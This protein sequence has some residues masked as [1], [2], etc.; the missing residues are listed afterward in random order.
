MTAGAVATWVGE[1]KPARVSA[2]AF[3]LGAVDP[4][5]VVTILVVSRELA[6]FGPAAA[7]TAMRDDLVAALAKTIDDELLDETRAPVAGANPG[8]ILNGVAPIAPSGV[9]AAAAAKDA[10]K[11]VAAFVTANPDTTRARILLPP[12][13]AV[14]IKSARPL[15]PLTLTGGSYLGVP[16]IVSG[17][18]GNRIVVVDGGQLLVADDGAEIDASGQATVQMDSTPDS[19]ATA[20][21]VM[22]SF[23]Q[24]NLVGLKVE[25]FCNWQRA[26]ATAVSLLSPTGYVPGS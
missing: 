16:A 7:D 26:K 21:T 6:K 15:E 11:T 18:V 5:K 14:L 22:T 13:T 23:W 3:A 17:T 10:D 12:A 1:G 8:S 2:E 25:R 4:A 20:A 24:E 19:P 9:D